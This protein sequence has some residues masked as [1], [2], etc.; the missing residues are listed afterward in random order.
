MSQE[1]VEI[2]RRMVESFNE[3]GFSADVTLDFFDVDA[4]SGRSSQLATSV[5]RL[6][7][8]P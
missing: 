6:A 7:G 8:S 1:N 4:V 3:V 2:V 5:S